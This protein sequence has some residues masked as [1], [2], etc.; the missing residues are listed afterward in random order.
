MKAI[1]SLFYKLFLLTLLILCAQM[2]VQAQ[3][4][5]KD[6]EAA[7]KA[8]VEARDYVFKAQ[9][10]LP[11]G[12][13]TVQLTSDFDMRVT[14]NEI[15]TYLPYYGRAY[16]APINPGEGGIRFTSTNFDYKVQEK[17]KRGWTIIIQPKDARDV[18]QLTLSISRSGYANLQVNSNNRQPISFTGYI[19]ERR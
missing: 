6:K 10:A 5:E 17:K 2:N 14:K 9:I 13:S 11:M 16:S 19:A 18:R 3:N 8:M 12:G 1:K 7:V 15:V 4:E